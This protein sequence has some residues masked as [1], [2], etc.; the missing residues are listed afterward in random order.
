MRSVLLAPLLWVTLLP[1]SVEAISPLYDYG[2]Q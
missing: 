2:E 1:T